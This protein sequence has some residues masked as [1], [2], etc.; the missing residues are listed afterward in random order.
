M[1]ERVST[2]RFLTLSPT[3][4]RCLQATARELRTV[5]N[6]ASWQTSWKTGGGAFLLFAPCRMQSFRLQPSDWRALP[7]FPKFIRS[8][9]ERDL[10]A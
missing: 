3:S 9:S 7:R 8:D 1:T 6:D 4:R 2:S 10:R 5:G